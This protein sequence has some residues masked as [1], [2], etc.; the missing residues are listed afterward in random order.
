MYLSRYADIGGFTQGD[1][2]TGL[3]VLHLMAGLLCI[4]VKFKRVKEAV[5][6]GQVF[7]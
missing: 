2:E 4:A 1:S 7:F 3:A 6:Y 5:F